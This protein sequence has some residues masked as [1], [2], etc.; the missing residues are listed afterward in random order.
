[1]LGTISAEH[2]KTLLTHIQES[3][4][5]ALLSHIQQ[6]AEY[7]SDFNLLLQELISVFHQI[8]LAQTIPQALR[9]DG[10]LSAETI[11]EFAT[12]FSKEDVQLYYQI[13]LLGRKDLPLATDARS[14][15]EMTLLRMLAFRP[16]HLDIQKTQTKPQTVMLTPAVKNIAS[17][18][19][20]TKASTDWTEIANHLVLSGTTKLLAS[21][22]SLKKIDETQIE[23]ILSPQY[24]AL[25]NDRVQER[26]ASALEAYFN[27][28]I[29]LV[30]ILDQSSHQ[31]PHEQ[32]TEEKAQAQD[33]L[34]NT[35]NQDNELKNLMSTFNVPLK[36]D[37]I[38]SH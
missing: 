30:I 1:M 26:L 35:L 3:N 8:A 5:Q 13:A 21:H 10:V 17:S 36:P 14:G 11:R 33:A 15:I 37:M 16:A 2:I 25:L 29:K 34:I 31:T 23:L 4:G 6:L 7:N 9:E 38:K 32:A 22:C 18:A 27:K 20:I 24:E 28:K 12:R 19:P